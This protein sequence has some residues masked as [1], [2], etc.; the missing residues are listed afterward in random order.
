MKKDDDF[1]PSD[2]LFIIVTEK[3]MG[4]LAV[5][6]TGDKWIYLNF[7]EGKSIINCVEKIRFAFNEEKRLD[8]WQLC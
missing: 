3:N 6:I 7:G 8:N 4:Y 2:D 5:N 1:W